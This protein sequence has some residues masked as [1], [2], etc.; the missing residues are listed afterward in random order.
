MRRVV[1]AALGLLAALL[2][3]AIAGTEPV[4]ADGGPFF[5]FAASKFADPGDHQRIEAELAQHLTDR[6]YLSL[7]VTRAFPA[8][9]TRVPRDQIFI[10]P[11]NLTQLA[12]TIRKGADAGTPGLL[13]YDGEHWEATPDEEQRDPP[14]A[15]L[16]GK[17]LAGKSPAH[18]FGFSP[19]GEFIGVRPSRCA[20]DLDQS[21][22]R[23][24]DWTGISLFNIQAQALLS[25]TCQETV[26]LKA[27]V[28]FVRAVALEA[29]AAAPNL[30]VTAKLSFRHASV[31]TMIEAIRRLGGTVDGFYLAYP[32]NVGPVCKY[33]A[34]AN[35]GAVLAAIRA[36]RPAAAPAIPQ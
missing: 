19:D 20:Y 10:L 13:I 33:C 15:V 16:R 22:H 27:Y 34:P 3:P 24:I 29:K 8:L 11:P 36:E 32:C 17:A 23:R 2:Q 1:A 12:A 6:D 5:M 31:A 18:R 21:I 30:T 14:A 4:P 7:G 26:G 35:L 28:D 25:E 9:A